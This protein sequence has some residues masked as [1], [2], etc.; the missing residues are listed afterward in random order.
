[1]SKYRSR[2]FFLVIIVL[3]LASVF[4]Y[5]DKLGGGEWVTII[6]LTLGMYKAANVV[7]GKHE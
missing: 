6:T 4:L 3:F 7:E 2:K 1:M 5:I